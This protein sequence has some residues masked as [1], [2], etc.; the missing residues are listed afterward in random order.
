M[1]VWSETFNTPLKVCLQ[2]FNPPLK[3][4]M[5]T[6]N[7]P[8]KIYMQNFNQ[9][10]NPIESLTANF[11]PKFQHHVHVSLIFE[12]KTQ[13]F[14]KKMNGITMPGWKTIWNMANEWTQT[15]VTLQLVPL[16]LAFFPGRM[17]HLA[18]F[19]RIVTLNQLTMKVGVIL[20]AKATLIWTAIIMPKVILNSQVI[21]MPKVVLNLK[22]ILISK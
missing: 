8:L 9:T 11:Q 6:C 18:G 21:L 17:K 16:Q 5:R 3:V 7:L 20:N 2:I 22:V 15:C 19:K 13:V 1:K 12:S 14:Q 4:C 10:C